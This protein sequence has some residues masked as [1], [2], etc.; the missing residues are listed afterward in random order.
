M[1]AA[2]QVPVRVDSE[3]VDV[4][5]AKDGVTWRAWAQFRGQRRI[6]VGRYQQVAAAGRLHVQGIAPRAP[7]SRPAADELQ[8]CP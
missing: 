5:V 8:D 6:T 7:D 1:S 4:W 3:H 2:K